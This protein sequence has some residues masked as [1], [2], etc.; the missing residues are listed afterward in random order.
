MAEFDPHAQ[1]LPAAGA[2]AACPV[3]DLAR[4]RPPE[5]IA[6]HAT[7]PYEVSSLHVDSRCFESQ[8]ALLSSQ[9]AVHAAD[10][11]GLAV[12]MEPVSAHCPDHNSLGSDLERA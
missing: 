10:E 1:C 2:G 5:N 3:R 7:T 11:L 12:V 6:W 4:V 9:D 8:N